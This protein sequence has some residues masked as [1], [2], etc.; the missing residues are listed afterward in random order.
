MRNGVKICGLTEEAGLEAAVTFEAD[1]IGFNFF[2]RSPRYVTPKQAERLSM[3]I[4]A[5]GPLRVG[6]FVKADDQEIAAVLD[7]VPLDILQIYD[8]P[9]RAGALRDLFTIPV[10]H[11]CAVSTVADLPVYSDLDGLLVEPRPLQTATRPGGNGQRFEDWSFLHGW[12]A[13]APWM[14][15]GGLSPAN[16]QRAMAQSGASSVDVSSGVESSPG[17]KSSLLIQKF[18][19][20][21]RAP[22]A[23]DKT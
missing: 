2:E 21:A 4:P 6:L 7:C 9:A 5:D 20:A 10:W 15:A 13:P 17:V 12:R 22:C 11:A 3:L 14:L 8:T 18:I 1:W 16:V 19:E 23:T